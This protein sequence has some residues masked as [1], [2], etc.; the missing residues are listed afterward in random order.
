MSI[1]V[2]SEAVESKLV[3]LDTSH[4]EILTRL[5]ECSLYEVLHKG[6]KLRLLIINRIKIILAQITY[7][8]ECYPYQVCEIACQPDPG[9][10]RLL[11]RSHLRAHVRA[12]Q[13]HPHQLDRP[14]GQ[15]ICDDLRRLRLNDVQSISSLQLKLFAIL[16]IVNHNNWLFG[17]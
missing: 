14:W 12:R 17:A 16:N 9:T 7:F 4:T 11:W 6:F 13:A 3:K 2:C 1:F 5:R 8:N 15:H 10:A